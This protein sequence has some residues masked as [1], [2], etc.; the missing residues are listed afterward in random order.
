M[1]FGHEQ[2]CVNCSL[3]KWRIQEAHLFRI[4]AACIEYTKAL[5]SCHRLP[6]SQQIDVIEI[7]DTL[8][9]PQNSL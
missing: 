9:R 4:I 1:D 6:E 5:S 3:Q 2:I 7:I 8:G